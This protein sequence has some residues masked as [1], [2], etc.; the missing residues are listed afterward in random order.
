MYRLT[1][2][3]GAVFLAI[4]P[5][6]AQAQQPAVPAPSY[7]YVQQASSMQFDGTTMTLQGVAPSTVFFSDRPNRL[8]GLVSS[9]QFVEL[10]NSP[11][12]PFAS[13]PPNAAVSVLGNIKDAPA[14]VELTSAEMDGVQVKY[15]VKVLSG[16]L[17]ASADNIAL[18]VDHG[19]NPRRTSATRRTGY[20]PYHP[21]HPV[22]GPYCYHAPQDPEC[23]Y[24]PYHPYPPY[25]PYPPYHP[26][27]Y[28]GA[29][30]AAGAVVGAAAASSNQPQTYIY[31][32]PAGPIP[33]HCYINSA[34][35]R[36]ICSVPIN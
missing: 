23:H 7:E 35:T 5:G 13:D 9:G 24:H 1:A 21:Y 2:L 27:Y 25:P 22:P 4:S 33:A 29:A 8:T 26:Y 31:P 12:G 19:P 10:W 3:I 6:L 30:F 28:P 34:H 15:G 36:M 14:I 16:E 11:D 17:P 20:Y 18:F 32:I